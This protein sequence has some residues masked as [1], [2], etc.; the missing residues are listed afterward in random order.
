MT[1]LRAYGGTHAVLGAALTCRPT[2]VAR[3][4]AG[5][6]ALPPLWVVRLLGIRLLA[7]GLVEL[8]RPTSGVLSGAA[9]VD[10][11]HAVSMIGVA[12]DARHRRVA[13][14]SAAVAGASAG[15]T[16]WT[17]MRLRRR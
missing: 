8:A 13:L 5:K 10:A 3:A 12:A 2:D 14:V 9:G 11:L 16:A 6:H 7:Q 4:V 15:L 17:A 1:A